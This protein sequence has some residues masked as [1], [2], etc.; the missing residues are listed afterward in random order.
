MQW[1]TCEA[2]DSGC[3]ILRFKSWGI[4]M[5]RKCETRIIKP[6]RWCWQHTLQLRREINGLKV[7]LPLLVLP[8]AQ[9]QMDNIFRLSWIKWN[10]E[11]SLVQLRLTNR[12][13]AKSPKFCIFWIPLTG[14]FSQLVCVN[15]LHVCVKCAFVYVSICESHL[16]YISL[17]W[18]IVGTY[19][20]SE[21]WTLP[22]GTSQWTSIKHEENSWGRDIMCDHVV[23]SSLWELATRVLAINYALVNCMTMP[24]SDVGIQF[25]FIDEPYSHSVYL[26]FLKNNPLWDRRC[27][28]AYMMIRVKWCTLSQSALWLTT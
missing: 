7:A 22:P 9:C 12:L 8:E 18:P 24:L 27:Q 16:T 14:G 13:P 21:W 2:S 6:M 11:Q 3:Q 28:L 25:M 15:K 26:Q 5:I 20:A 10:N 1:Y 4:Y 17:R 19:L 23:Y